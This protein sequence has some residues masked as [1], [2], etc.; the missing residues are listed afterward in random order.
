M[1]ILI[2]ASYSLSLINFRGHLIRSMLKYGH[3]V[4]CV[5][6]DN[7]AES[8]VIA[9]GAEFYT[10]PLQRAAFNPCNDITYFWKLL[11]LLNF[12][13]PD[14]VLSYTIK[15]VIYG[16]LAARLKQV[17]KI[18]S[19]I[20]GLGYAF[21][22][23]SAK[24]RA[25]GLLAKSLYRV[26]LKHAEK[27]FFQNPDDLREF[28]DFKIV[29]AEKTVLVNGSGVDLC[30]FAQEQ[31]TNEPKFLLIA[32][33]LK[34]KGIHDYVEAARIVKERYPEAVFSIVGPPDPSPSGL[35]LREIEEY[36]KQGVINYHGSTSDVR[37]FIKGSNIYVLPSYR[38]GTPRTVLES[39]AMGRPIITTDAPGCRETV[40]DGYN[41]FLIPV[42][43]ANALADAMMKFLKDPALAYRMGAASRK[44]AEEKYD[45]HEVNCVI[46]ASMDL[47]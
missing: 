32:R 13:K 1:R 26:A 12:L 8:S 47:I 4:V 40:K 35:S 37:P 29:T 42:K 2:L 39:M 10:V 15:P 23:G 34:E 19:I 28:L 24:Q 9:M 33:L 22:N 11:C 20:T 25:S 38:E 43:N 27:V 31:L 41:G 30:Q 14:L 45:V 21:M 7:A 18:Y 17:P 46:L 5:A 44:L 3:K 16:S 36:S 6:P